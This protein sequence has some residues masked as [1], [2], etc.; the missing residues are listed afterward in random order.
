VN[1]NVAISGTGRF[2]RVLIKSFIK[3]TNVIA[4]SSQGN[5][6]NINKTLEISR[7][8][9]FKNNLD[10]ARDKNI[11]SVI[12]ATP[13]NSLY[14]TA[15]L[16][17]SHGKNV[18]LE[19]PGAMK[20]YEMSH[21]ISLLSKGQILYVDYLTIL[22]PVY[23]RFKHRLKREKICKAR[24]IWEKTGSF[25]SDIFLN[26]LCHS[27]SVAHDIFDNE[28]VKI[29]DLDYTK[30][31]CNVILQ[32]G[33]AP[34]EITIDRSKSIYSNRFY[35]TNKNNETYQWD[36]NV[37]KFFLNKDMLFEKN[38]FD[39]VDMSRDVFLNMVTSNKKSMQN[40]ELSIKI[41]ETIE[42]IKK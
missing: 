33:E 40:L 12:V 22:D 35:V 21:L 13:I 9:K 37:G 10:I 25:E 11:Y 38:D 29:L 30:A 18:F 41:L 39:L 8:I 42:K 26:L 23:L 6:S 2:G 32:F 27:L 17:I 1:H 34:L 15:K 24:F 7:N 36:K 5:I 14:E 16:F 19:K 20:S 3:K 28:D 4:A 31:Y